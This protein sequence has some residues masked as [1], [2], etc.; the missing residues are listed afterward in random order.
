MWLVTCSAFT[1][2]PHEDYPLAGK[3]GSAEA[4][5][6][7]ATSWYA[8]YGPTTDPEHVVVVLVEEGGLG[9]EIA[10]PAA[11]EIWDAILDRR[12]GGG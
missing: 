5:G 4:F 11:R 1:G 8:S 9:S 2:W 6:Q 3:T 10:A 12:S 7:I